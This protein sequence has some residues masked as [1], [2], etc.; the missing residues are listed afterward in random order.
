MSEEPI[1]MRDVAYLLL[2]IRRGLTY[3]EIQREMLRFVIE[4]K[5]VVI[6]R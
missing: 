4:N 3:E 6:I 2:L 1:D 5:G